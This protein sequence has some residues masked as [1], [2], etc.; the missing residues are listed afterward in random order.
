MI[1]GSD[2]PPT[3]VLM[4]PLAAVLAILA[5]FLILAMMFARFDGLAFL[6]P[7]TTRGIRLSA[8][9]FC[10]DQCRLNGICPMTGSETQAADCALF[11]YVR[12]DVPT[13]VY[14]SPFE[15]TTH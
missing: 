7:N 8:T 11:K 14:G 6:A 9:R 3:E 10:T 5:I 1:V 12:A 4:E 15:K 13:T 2:H